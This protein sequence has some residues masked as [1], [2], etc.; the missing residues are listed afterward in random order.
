MRRNVIGAVLLTVLVLGALGAAAF[1]VYQIGY[2]QGLVET[3]TE[4]VVN[5][6]GF[7]PGYW[8]PGFWGFGFFGIFFKI[9]FLFLIFGLI[10]RLFFGRRHWGGGPGPYWAKEWHEGHT[11]P[12]EQR[13]TDWHEKAHGAQPPAEPTSDQGT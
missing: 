10:A 9:L 6:P 7:H 8:G 5:T 13:L 2:Q 1:G 12:M 11:S 4:V 3:G